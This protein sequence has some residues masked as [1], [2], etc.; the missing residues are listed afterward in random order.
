MSGAKCH[1]EPNV[2][3]FFNKNDLDLKNDV[4]NELM[5]DPSVTS[6]KVKVSSKDGIITLSGSVPHYI[7]KMSAEKAAQRVGGVRVVADELEVMGALDKSD[8]EIAEASL[9]AIKWK[10]SV[11]DDVKISVDHGWITLTG[12][13][14][15]NY[16]RAAA[17]S[18]VADL[19]GVNG[20]TN[21][22]K[23][24]DQVL[25][26]DVKTRIEEALKRSAEAEGRKIHVVVQGDTVTLTGN[27]HSFGEVE[28]AR[29]AA[30]AA[31]GV[32]TVINNLT[33]SQ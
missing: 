14:D 7:E 11:P 19:L 12:D 15:W 10:Y 8:E 29:F 33:I 21:S 3:N 1:K 25:P 18:A 20:V 17:E 13:V 28:D 24:K 27:V 26:S 2:F 16:Q 22:I 4:I 23:I 5:W 6:S 30:W 31:P 32:M 9:N